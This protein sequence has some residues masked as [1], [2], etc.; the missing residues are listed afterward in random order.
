MH[1]SHRRTPS[2]ALVAAAFTLALHGAV[3]LAV[4]Q[5]PAAEA[6]G[7]ADVAAAPENDELTW[8]L[9]AGGTH[10][11]GNTNAWLVTS[12]TRFRLV[13]G[14]HAFSTEGMFNFGQAKA[15]A[16]M[17]DL[18]PT[19]TTTA[20]NLNIKARYE[21][22]MTQLDAL[23]LAEIF[24]WDTFAGLD[25]R[26]QTQVGY[27]RNFIRVPQHRLWAEAGYDLTLDNYT[28]NSL[29]PNTDTIH[30]ARLMAGYNNELNEH[31]VLITELE[32]LLNVERPKDLRVN[33]ML[34]LRSTLAENF[35]AELS[36]T[37]KFD[38]E[39][40]AGIEK[41]DTLTQVNLIYAL[42]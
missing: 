37:L 25:S 4:A 22:F 1:S 12:G 14:S 17:T 36:F 27:Q 18:N 35:K 8:A 31:V 20:R 5:A 3:P 39:V 40:P 9:L 19:F 33:Y 11:Y 26:F 7:H 21:F 30:A 2:V 13:R 23:F 32:G 15:K 24:R 6:L 16:S 42:M 28:P 29:D 10:N 38:N 41:V 34:G